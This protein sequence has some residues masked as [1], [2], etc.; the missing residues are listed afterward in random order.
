VK[1]VKF[2]EITS[3]VIHEMAKGHLLAH[4]GKMSDTSFE[5]NCGFRATTLFRAFETTARIIARSGDSPATMRI[6]IT[7]EN[8]D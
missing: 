8:V 3:A 7:M 6:V 2:K 5:C 1:P 4:G